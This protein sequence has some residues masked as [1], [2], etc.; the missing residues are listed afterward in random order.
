MEFE[1]K[2]LTRSLKYHCD[3]LDLYEDQVLLPNGKKA[4]RVYIDHLG[5]AAI[6]PVTKDKKLVLTRQFRYPIHQ[7]SLEVPAGKKD[8]ANE[9]SKLCAMRELEEETSYISEDI[10]FVQRIYNCL[11]YSNEAIDL[12]IAFDC[13]YKEDALH[14]DEDEFIERVV[15]GVKEVEQ[16]LDE[17]EITDVKT[18][19]LVQHYLRNYGGE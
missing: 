6:L 16:M 10:R 9:D 12:F 1:E 17:G 3:F 18:A 15:L 5:A 7:V 13:V 19:L 4:S 11:G 2:F 8:E 14:A